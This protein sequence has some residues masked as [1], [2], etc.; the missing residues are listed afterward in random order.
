[1]QTLTT[2]IQ[3]VE[4][5]K[6]KGIKVRFHDRQKNEPAHYCGQCEVSRGGNS[7]IVGFDSN[8]IVVF[9]SFFAC[10]LQLEVFNVLF[11]RENEKRHV[12]HCLG[13]ARKQSAHL[14]GFVCLE[15]YR[16]TEL[17]AIYDAFVLHRDVGAA[18]VDKVPPLPPTSSS[19]SPTQQ[20]LSNSQLS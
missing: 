12:V 16:L 1:M 14:Q 9:L 18:C 15:E 7:I 10:P 17:M 19:R 8:V 11:V 20:V 4:F 3:S 5:A 13:C 6:A 2:V